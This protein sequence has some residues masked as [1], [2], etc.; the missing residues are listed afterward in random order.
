MVRVYEEAA[1]WVH[2]SRV[3]GVALNTCDL[4]EHDAATAIERA[5]RETGLPATDPVR[6]GADPLVEAIAQAAARRRAAGSAT[7]A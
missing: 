5:A 7:P 2:P 4:S 1:G 3:I 6:F